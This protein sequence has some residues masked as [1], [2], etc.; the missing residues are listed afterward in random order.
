MSNQLATTHETS[1]IEQVMILG[2]L[3][4]LTPEQRVKYYTETCNSLG[5]N[6]MTRPF[7]YINLS[8]KL[9][10][11]PK[12]DATEQLRKIHG[13]SIDKPELQFSDDLLIVTVTG[14]DKT[15]RRDTDIGVVTIGS[16]RGDAKAN[17][18]MKAITKAKRRLTLSICGL[19][20]MDESEI[21][22]VPDAHPV[23]V[24]ENGVIITQPKHE[25]GNGHEPEAVRP[26]SA[27]ETR[28]RILDLAAKYAAKGTK[29]NGDRNMIVPNFEKLFAENGSEKR[30][31]VTRYLFGFASS[32][33]L[34]DPQ[35]L[36]LKSWM[37]YGKLDTGEWVANS[38]SMQ[39]AEA[40]YTAALVE[41]GQEQLL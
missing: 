21:E 29:A 40:M 5:L 1:I 41:D 22:T 24:A 20:W 36:A 25:N 10:L 11:Y 28:R 19:G 14:Q 3:S 34:S 32:K 35:L 39:E 16:L 2:D 9:T 12:K 7:D 31:A 18:V 8:G 6:P 26:Y 23:V 38:Y 17:A 27:E 30:H 15:G 4:K 33:D 13:V 37:D